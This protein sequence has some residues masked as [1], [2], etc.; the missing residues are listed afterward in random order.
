MT[1]DE[2]WVIEGTLVRQDKSNKRAWILCLIIFLAFVISNSIWI[3]YE[4][5]WRYVDT[6]TTQ[7][8]QEVDQEVEGEGSNTFIGGNN[9]NET[10]STNSNNDK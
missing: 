2:R 5:Q 4:S 8:E 7:I 3:W 6:T 9:G 10:D 1:D